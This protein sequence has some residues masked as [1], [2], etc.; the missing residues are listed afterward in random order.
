MIP[1]NPN[2][3]IAAVIKANPE[4]M[5]AIASIA[6]PFRKLRN[7][8]LR[9]L[10]APRITIAQA[11]AVGGCKLGDFERVLEPLGFS[12]TLTNGEESEPNAGAPAPAWFDARSKEKTDEFDVRELIESGEDPLKQIVQRY[13]RLPKGHTL[14]IINSFV[15]YPLLHVLGQKGAEHHV[16]TKSASLH[17]TWFYK[18]GTSDTQDSVSESHMTFLDTL[19]FESILK[20]FSSDKT[21]LLDVRELPMPQ[22]METILAALAELQNDQ[23]I[24]VYHRRVPLH[25][26][27]ELDGS[28][29]QVHISDYG[30]G[31]IRLL[32]HKKSD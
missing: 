25:L 9:R 27:E 28:G 29:I 11:A 14:C 6:P 3:T 30:P 18:S 19:S 12:F 10:M 1:I 7:P 2:T 23:V 31:D 17:Y 16:E 26:L 8:I 13:K 20:K 32:L 24:Y 5:E 4:S 15:P 21:I 22:P